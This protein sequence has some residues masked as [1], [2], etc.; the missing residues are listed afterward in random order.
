[1][2]SS[3]VQRKQS[4]V[5]KT[6]NNNGGG[7]KKQGGPVTTGIT[8]TYWHPTLTRTIIKGQS[9][10]SNGANVAA[11]TF[12]PV[13]FT[14]NIT[15]ASPTILNVATS[16]GTLI[17]GHVISGTGIPSGTT[18]TVING[19]TVTMSLPATATTA[20]L[21]IT[22]AASNIINVTNVFKGPLRLGQKITG[23][24]IP[25]NTTISSFGTGTGENGT[26]TLSNT[27]TISAINVD[28]TG[29]ITYSWNNYGETYKSNPYRPFNL[30]GFGTGTRYKYP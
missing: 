22:G 8:H 4:V 24:G 7:M 23:S 14:G 18:V 1:M 6:D 27:S 3:R 29:E 2:P 13:T 30:F 15:S 21:A 9:N 26:Y 25:A 5:Q 16:I 20:T 19:T 17:V 28:I 10:G 12:G 11:T